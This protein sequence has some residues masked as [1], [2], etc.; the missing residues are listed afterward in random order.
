MHGLK[1]IGRLKELV[2]FVGWSDSAWC[3]GY[4]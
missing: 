1:V 2:E 3:E 4:K